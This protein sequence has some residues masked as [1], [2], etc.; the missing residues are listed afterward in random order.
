MSKAAHKPNKAELKA[1]KE[2]VDVSSSLPNPLEASTEGSELKQ[3]EEPSASLT[4]DPPAAPD[5]APATDKTP[6]S[7]APTASKTYRVRVLRGVHA[8]STGVYSNEDGWFDS[9]VDL[10]SRFGA[11]KFENYQGP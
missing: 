3:Q 5:T 10:V 1:A 4:G 9:E 6:A 8:D 11:D 2:A 7:A